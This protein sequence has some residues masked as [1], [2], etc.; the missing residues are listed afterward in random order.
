M[1]YEI[2]SLGF[3]LP[4]VLPM[5]NFALDFNGSRSKFFKLWKLSDLNCV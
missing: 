3:G 2:V 5:G 1:E 4:R